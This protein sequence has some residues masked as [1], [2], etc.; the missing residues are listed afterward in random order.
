[1]NLWPQGPL[2]HKYFAYFILLVSGVLLASEATGLYFAYR[3]TRAS[4]LTLQ[5]E[6]AL[7]AAVRIEQFATDIKRQI[8][9][10]I[11][12]H[13]GG[14]STLEQRYLELLKLLR[15]VPA[16]TTASWLDAS[17][18]EQ[19][20]VSRL[21]MDRIGSGIDRAGD[22]AFQQPRPE[23][24][25]FGPV[26][27]R[28]E[29][30]PYMTIAAASQTKGEGITVVEVNLKFVWD[31]I[32]RIRIGKTGYAYVVDRRGQ[33]L[34][35]PNISR[36]L[37]KSD[38]SGLPQVRRALETDIRP[39]GA[40]RDPGTGRDP[41]GNPI[42]SAHAPIAELEWFVIVEQPLAEAY[43]PLYA[44]VGRTGLLLLVAFPLAVLAS[45][46]LARHITMP[47]RALQQGAARIG[48]GALKHRIEVTTGDEL[49]TLA[50]EFNRMAARLCRSYTGLERKVAARTRELERAN[51]AR[52]RFLRAASHDLRQ[53]MHAL[54]LFIAQLNARAQDQET[55]RIAAQAE[56]AV[57]TL[58]ELLDAI[59][60]ISR[61][62]AGVIMPEVADFGVNLLLDRLD[63]AFA[64]SAT[65]KGLR[66][67]VVPSRLV[68]RSD[69]VL[70]ERILLNLVAN[71][72]RYT[73]RG[74]ILIGCRRRGTRVRIL[75]HDTGVGIPAE[76]Q[77]AIFEEFYQVARSEHPDEQG[78]GL[79]LAISARLAR[80]LG[81]S[82]EVASHPGKGSVFAVE[83][84]RGQAPTIPVSAAPAQDATDSLRGAL[85]LIVDDDALV[86]DAM[87][88]LLTDWHCEVVDV[89]GG[90]E[91]VDA[92]ERLDRLPDAILC[93]YRLRGEKT[94][95]QVIRQLYDITGSAIPAALISGDI[96]P[97]TLRKA[98]ASGYPLIAKPVAP[99]KLRALIEY[100]VSASQPRQDR[101][102]DDA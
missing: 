12:P 75:V 67:R 21:H 60:D 57:T 44:A 14:G 65:E 58:Q 11:L 74:G 23:K 22:P 30:E 39:D 25:Y 3:E 85:V 6:K 69:P 41:Q 16:I 82:I 18:H 96:A 90:D 84:P 55:R 17:G 8:G 91:A 66:F 99:S 77:R 54:G 4:L 48:A 98:K 40:S 81:S 97:E 68:V 38:F 70:L 49:Q 20:R 71:A 80:L 95:I 27:F 9:W 28:A 89:A 101:P 52:S 43:A 5:R 100:L 31:V 64:A 76:Q 53:P 45:L 24:P 51:Q 94:G 88:S 35:H 42:L 87:R 1:M 26:Y 50:K 19:L 61:L 32:S 93:D 37:Q 34:S 72:V 33:L 10:T 15:Q 79:G 56:V 46:A 63:T 59:L 83:V 92:L 86:R 2:F 29:T 7:G 62:D 78:M 73:E 13:P 102:V 47:I 36:V